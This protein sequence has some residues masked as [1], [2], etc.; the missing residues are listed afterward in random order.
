MSTAALRTPAMGAAKDTAAGTRK[1]FF[2]R[3]IDAMMV[4]QSVRAERII[5]PHFA[6]LPDSELEKLGFS[7]EKLAQIRAY[8]DMASG[9]Y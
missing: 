7:P 9:W 4:A 3:V 6:A 5:Y 8:R 2:A 1:G